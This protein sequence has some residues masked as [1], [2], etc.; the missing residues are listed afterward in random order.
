MNDKE[1]KRF[2]DRLAVQRMAVALMALY[3][4]ELQRWQ[5]IWAAEDNLEAGTWVVI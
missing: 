3:A 5:A 4:F 2:H 1:R